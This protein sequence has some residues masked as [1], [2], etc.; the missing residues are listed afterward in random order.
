MPKLKGLLVLAA[1]L[2]LSLLLAG[3]NLLPFIGAEPDEPETLGE[4]GLPEWLLSEHRGARSAEAAED[5][6]ELLSE[7]E[8]DEESDE[9]NDEPTGETAE[10][11]PTG[12][13]A[14]TQPQ[15]QEAGA[16]TSFDSED[17]AG[18]QEPQTENVTDRSWRD[19][20]YTGEWLDGSPH[21]RGTFTHSSGAKL[22]GNWLNG[23]PDGRIRFTDPSGRT[24]TMTFD[25]GNISDS[26]WWNPDSSRDSDRRFFD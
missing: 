8:E 26:D 19:G 16:D 5:E 4:E 2:L 15:Q 6:D 11:Q 14:P 12:D 18:D 1:I 24:E 7:D 21:G 23:N 22:A 25:Q 17:P 9:D 10:Q 13:A 20:S 3:C